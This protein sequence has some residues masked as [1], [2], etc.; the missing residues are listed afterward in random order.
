MTRREAAALILQFRKY[1][2]EI[3]GVVSEVKSIKLDKKIGDIAA[4]FGEEDAYVF[5]NRAFEERK[6]TLAH[7]NKLQRSAEKALAIL[8]EEAKLLN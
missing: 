3:A 5:I 2:Q 1:L 8:I 7:L 6:N 4:S